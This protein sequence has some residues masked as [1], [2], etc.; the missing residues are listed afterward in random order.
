LVLVASPCLSAS[1]TVVRRWVACC[2][3]RVGQAEK[4][5]GIVV[6]RAGCIVGLVCAG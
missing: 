2:A 3:V 1:N 4:Q 6:C 5:L